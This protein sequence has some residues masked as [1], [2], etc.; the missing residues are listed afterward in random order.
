MRTP[1]TETEKREWEAAREL[2]KAQLTDM[3]ASLSRQASINRAL[4]LG[5]MPLLGARIVRAID[6]AGLLGNGLRIVDTNAIYAYEAAAGVQVDPGITAT[7]DIDLLMDARRRLRMFADEGV[8]AGS[9]IA[10]L[11][12]VDRSFERTPEP[13]RARNAT[14]YLVDLIKPMPKPPWRSEREEIGPSADDLAAVSIDGPGWLENAPLFETVVIDERGGPLRFVAS[15]PRVFAAHKL[16]MST[17]PDR[18][19]VKRGRDAAQA[20][21]VGALTGRYLTHLPYDAKA[22]RMIPRRLFEQASGLFQAPEP[23]RSFAF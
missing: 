10:L 20:A 13:F 18:D 14:G 11:R 2:A 8:Q 9:L 21:A 1:E 16:W 3:T 7:L 23:P 12:K 6:D 19:P 17:R 4:N 15:D 22:L 5:G